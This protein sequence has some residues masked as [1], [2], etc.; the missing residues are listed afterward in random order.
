MGR[1]V[2]WTVPLVED[3]IPLTSPGGAGRAS[4][5][6]PG[7]YPPPPR[8]RRVVPVGGPCLLSAHL[9]SIDPKRI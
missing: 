9:L 2:G 5:E 7:T 4:T 1:T 8:D 3:S 6:T